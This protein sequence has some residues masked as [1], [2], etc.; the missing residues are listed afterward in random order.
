MV[1]VIAV[2]VTDPGDVA[3]SGVEAAGTGSSLI[4]VEDTERGVDVM[5][6]FPLPSPSFPPAVPVPYG[7]VES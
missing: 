6:P 1:E 5:A 3:D 7:A 4:E 2:V